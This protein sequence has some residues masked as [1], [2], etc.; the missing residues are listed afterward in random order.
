MDY[1]SLISK[2]LKGN[3]DIYLIGV[4]ADKKLSHLNQSVSNATLTLIKKCFDNNSFTG[5]IG[6]NR[7]FDDAENKLH[8]IQK[9]MED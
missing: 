6:D 4:F 8:K 1:K 5:D 3:T 2:K 7:T 9:I